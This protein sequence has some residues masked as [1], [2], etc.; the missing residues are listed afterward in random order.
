MLAE[1][2]YPTRLANRLVEELKPPARLAAEGRCT[3]AAALREI[4]PI[5]R[6]YQ[7]PA[8]VDKLAAAGK[9]VEDV[10]V[11]LE[12]NI[13]SLA[14]NQADL[15]RMEANAVNMRQAAQVF[16][17]G[18]GDLKKIMWWRNAKLNVCIGV[19]LVCAVLVI[20]LLFIKK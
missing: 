1:A 15:D 6:R 10:K 5:V 20:V 11:S 12:A 7:D 16:E 19:I 18:T 14:N 4:E 17:K 13:S 3:Q 8:R 9:K 2:S